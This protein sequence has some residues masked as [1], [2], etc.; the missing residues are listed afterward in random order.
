MNPHDEEYQAEVRSY[1]IWCEGRL[2][3]LRQAGMFEGD[4]SITNTGL[5]AYRNL[6]QS[7]FRPTKEK[8]V[9]TLR[10]LQRFEESDLEAVAALL[11]EERQ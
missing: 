5:V 6:V 8:L 4:R 7:G 1:L 9:R 3:E 11:M 10:S 2:E